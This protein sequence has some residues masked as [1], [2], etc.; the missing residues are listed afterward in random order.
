M[1]KQ[2]TI[3]AAALL[4]A[5][6]VFAQSFK[7]SAAEAPS[8]DLFTNNAKGGYT[9]EFVNAGDVAGIQFDIQDKNIREGGF[10][11]GGSLNGFE[12]SC[13]LNAEQGYLRVIVFSMDA[14]LVPDATLVSINTTGGSIKKEFT[15]PS[16][17]GVI[18]SDAQGR[19]ITPGHLN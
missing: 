9:V 5:G 6:A 8:S 4:M 19:N 12:T 17:N 15:R 2:V 16:L 10:T 1:F 14:A 18:L 11:C 3:A 13:T 7:E